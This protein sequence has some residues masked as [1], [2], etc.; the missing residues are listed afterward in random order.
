MAAPKMKQT[1]GSDVVHVAPYPIPVQLVK[2]EGQPPI[3]GAI[4]RMTEIGFLAK[5]DGAHFFTVGETWHLNLELP[6][7]HAPVKTDGKIIKTYD[8][9]ERV[10]GTQVKIKTVEIHFKSLTGEQRNNIENYLVQ[11]AQKK[12]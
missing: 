9:L 10:G 8:G 6:A 5:V 1:S 11:S 7:S 2:T 4:L 3:K 12:R